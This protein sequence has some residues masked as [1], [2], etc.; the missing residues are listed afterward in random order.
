MVAKPSESFEYCLGRWLFLQ[1]S[2]QHRRRA[3]WTPAQTVHLRR[4]EPVSKRRRLSPG[5]SWFRVPMRGWLLGTPMWGTTGR[6]FAGSADLCE[7]RRLYPAGLLGSWW[8]LQP[9]QMDASALQMP[10]R[11]RR[12]FLWGRRERMRTLQRWPLPEWSHLPEWARQLFVPLYRGI[13]GTTLWGE[14]RRL[15]GKPLLCRI[16]LCGWDFTLCLSL[17]TGQD[18]YVVC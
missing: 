8:W 17:R 11:L 1:L 4:P 18:W 6:L 12:R 7:R 10:A 3:L 14:H 16:D 2:V 15:Q 13:H 9:R 5:T